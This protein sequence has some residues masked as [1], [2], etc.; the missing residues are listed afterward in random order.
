LSTSNRKFVV[1]YI[2][3]VGIP[4]LA[5]VG[6]LKAGRHLTSPYAVD[7]SWKLELSATPAASPCSNTLS[8][9]SEPAVNVSQS[10]AALVLSLN[11]RTANGTLEGKSMRA[12]FS[13]ADGA[14]GCSG[15]ALMLAATLDPNT[16]PRTLTGTLSFKGCPSCSVDFRAVRQPPAPSGGSH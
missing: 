13:G 11:G 14:S 4:L 1:A 15:Q 12:E 2:F 8:S 7:G 9:I 10:G 6:V 16:L 5:L 3:L